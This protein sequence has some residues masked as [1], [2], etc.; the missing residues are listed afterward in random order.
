MRKRKMGCA[1]LALLIGCGAFAQE[2]DDTYR[3]EEEWRPML[4]TEEALFFRAVQ[5]APDLYGRATDYDLSFVAG[6]RRGEA[7]YEK[8]AELSGIAVSRDCVSALRMLSFPV[9]ATAGIDPAAGTASGVERFDA[10]GFDAVPRRRV[11]V[12]FTDRNYRAG[13]RHHCGGEWNDWRLEAAADLR[14]GR[15]LRIEGVRTRAVA[16]ALR[17]GKTWNDD[18]RLSLIAIL[19]LSVRGLRGASTAEAFALTGDRYY[20]PSWGFQN[21]RLRNAR[22]RREWLPV[23][24][25]VFG[26]R[27]SSSTSLTV[28]VGFQ[29]G[30]RYTSALE[31]FDATTPVPDNYRRMPSFFTDEAV[32]AAVAERWRTE[33]ARYTQIDWDELYAEN[34]M[35]RGDAAFVLAD[36]AR[37]IGIL[38]AAATFRTVAGE[39]LALDYGL[40]VACERTRSYKVL[41]DLLGAEYLTDIDCFLAD[42]ATYRNSLQ[43]DLRHPDRRV[44]E[45]DRYGY[46]YA[47]NVRETALFARAG[48]RSGAF[49]LDVGLRIADRSVRRRGFYEKELFPGAGSSGASKRIVLRPYALTLATGYSF[50]PAAYLGLRLQ[51]GAVAPEADDLFLQPQYNNRPVDS[52]RTAKHHAA[53]IAFRLRQGSVELHAATFAVLVKDGSAVRRYYDDLAA[54]YCDRV[55][56]GIGTLACGVEAA[57]EIRPARRWQLTLAAAGA[58][59]KYVDDPTVTL[60]RDTDNAPVDSGSRSYMTGCTRG[61]APQIVASGSVDHFGRRWGFR[62][63][64]S[65]AGSRWVDPD[66]VR[67]TSRVARQASES[68]EAFD[69]FMVQE[70]L[71]DVFAIDAFVWKS[72]YFGERRLTLSLSMRNLTG[73]AAPYG[74]YESPR[75]RR[76]ASGAS[77]LRRPFDNRYTYM[78]GRSFF[79]SI[80]F[81]F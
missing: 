14:T 45:G 58:R 24:A 37:R 6:G 67:R 33:D 77:I 69:L 46:D 39:R 50:S 17:V 32:A 74:G 60:Y 29:A 70:R 40:R 18:T 71:A 19:P 10:L 55:V 15:D 76:I 35:R 31:W 21:G 47:L 28:S 56:R 34:R 30:V 66:P 78:Y 27:I 5:E 59:Y 23:V 3:W 53:E 4:R 51:T 68:P 22:V 52:P 44:G 2:P 65:F 79:L 64:G 75:L 41:R 72:F 73:E 48:Y 62:L 80:S 49:L 63:T 42:D 43:N 9:T 13:A 57:V 61:G 1:L 8:I 54:V 7:F 20:N 26:T 11:A 25:A 81:D 36:R 38:Q 12:R 16:A